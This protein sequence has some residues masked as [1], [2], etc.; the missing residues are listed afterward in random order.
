MFSDR[1]QGHR[2]PAVA[3]A[4]ADRLGKGDTVTLTVSKGPEMITVPDVTGK[5]VDDAKKK[6]EDRASRSR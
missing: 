3:R 2:R 4:R 1:G 6:L 5:N